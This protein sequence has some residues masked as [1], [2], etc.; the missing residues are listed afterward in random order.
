M[1]ILNYIKKL[2]S[3]PNAH[4]VCRI[5]LTILVVII[6]EIGFSKLKLIKTYWRSTMLQD[7]LNNL[8]ILSIESDMLELINY[9]TLLK[10]FATQTVRN[11][12]VNYI[13]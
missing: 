6:V 5:L 12:I 9:K 8:A 4:I 3:L 1:K 11:E 2:D 13:D 7:R 10:N